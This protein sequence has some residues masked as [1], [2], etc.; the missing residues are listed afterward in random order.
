MNPLWRLIPTSIAEIEGGQDKR[1]DPGDPILDNTVLVS[2]AD[3][4]VATGSSGRMANG[5]LEFHRLALVSKKRKNLGMPEDLISH[6]NKATRGSTTRIYNASWK[7]YVDWCTTTHRDPTADNA[8]QVL[9]FLN[10]FAHFSRSTLNGYRSPIA[11]VLN[12]IHPTS[13]PL[14]EDPDIIAFFW[15]KRQCTINIPNLSSLE[16]WVQTHMLKA[17]R[18]KDYK[19][20]SI[21]AASSTKAV[22]SGI[23]IFNVKNHANWSQGSNTFERYYYKPVAQ[24]H[25][26]TK[27]QNSIFQQT[28]NHTTSESKA[29]ATNIVLGTTYNQQNTTRSSFFQPFLYLTAYIFSLDITVY[30]Q[31]PEKTLELLKC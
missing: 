24:D 28:E 2:N 22:K 6:L 7:K 30:F 12:V 20:H 16:T 4:H 5:P 13:P 31:C 23:S 19:A 17:G 14:A 10:E 15:A 3:E 27:I 25:D 26:S 11:S 29:K 9:L 21:R 1:G 8:K 18:S